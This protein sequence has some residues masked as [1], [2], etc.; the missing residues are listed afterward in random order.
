M[1]FLSKFKE[2][3]RNRPIQVKSETTITEKHAPTDESVR[4]LHEMKHA[5]EDSLVLSLQCKSNQFS[6]T[7]FVFEDHSLF[8]RRMRV[9]FSLGDQPYDLSVNIEADA[10]KSKTEALIIIRDMVAKEVA[11]L[12]LMGSYT[13][14]VKMIVR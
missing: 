8:E 12:I 11:N 2:D 7:A 9:R 10:A 3:E 13:D 4:L 1:S 6:F 14:L 5:A